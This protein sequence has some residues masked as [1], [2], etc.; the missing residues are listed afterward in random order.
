[1]KGQEYR[2][3]TDT[4]AVVGAC[5]HPSIVDSVTDGPAGTIGVEISPAGA[6]R[7][8]RLSLKE[9]KDQSTS[10][11]DILG[12]T[13]RELERRL[14][15]LESVEEKV[16]ALQQFLVT[17][18]AQRETDRVFEHCVRAIEAARGGLRIRRLEQETG[19][20]SRW[21]NRKFEERLGI[22]PKN[23]S[24]IVR[25]QHY[26]QAMLANRVEFFRERRFYL[27]YHDESHFIKEFK[28]FTGFSP[29]QLIR[30]KNQ[31]GSMFY[32]E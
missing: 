18:S 16:G 21:L 32:Q 25:F 4:I 22:S 9:L 20:S 13:G 27:H 28:R 23:F 29:A 26:Y 31:F 19:Y 1:M 14:S 7:F 8:F 3:E 17:L 12:R 2:S 11:A 24:S 5:S 6:Y 15:G 10:L 30:S